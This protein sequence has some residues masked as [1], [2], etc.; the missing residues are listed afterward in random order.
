MTPEEGDPFPGLPFCIPLQLDSQ[1]FP[2]ADKEVR[3]LKSKNNTNASPWRWIGGFSHAKESGHSGFNDFGI[4]M[5]GSGPSPGYGRC[6][7][8]PASFQLVDRPNPFLIHLRQQL[9]VDARG[10]RWSLIHKR[11]EHVRCIRAGLKQTKDILARRDPAGHPN[12]Q[13]LA[14]GRPQLPDDVQRVLK[15]RPAG[16]RCLGL[17]KPPVLDA[18]VPRR[19]NAR[20][21]PLRPRRG[22]ISMALRQ[23]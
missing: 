11:R 23:S 17:R 9:M 13:P 21:V 6:G 12:R 20:P 22:V 18:E 14:S 10:N 16:Q 8:R 1:T 3:T 2:P 19:S 15:A 5:R 7:L 4:K